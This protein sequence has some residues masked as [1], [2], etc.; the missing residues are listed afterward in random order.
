MERDATR[1][2]IYLIDGLTNN[3]LYPENICVVMED[4]GERIPVK[5]FNRQMEERAK[6][7][8]DNRV[9]LK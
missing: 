3:F 2:G 5:E 7:I 6:R 8:W 4:T 1:L 9:I